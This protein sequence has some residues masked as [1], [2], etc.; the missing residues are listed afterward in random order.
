MWALKSRLFILFQ[1][2]LTSDPTISS[3]FDII[4]HGELVDYLLHS[5]MS[6]LESLQPGV[7]DD[8]HFLL[9]FNFSIKPFSLF[10]I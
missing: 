2:H 10:Q 1:W 3:S 6:A 7:K 5:S 9:F 8:A 4:Y